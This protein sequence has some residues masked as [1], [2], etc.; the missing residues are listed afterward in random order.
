[1]AVIEQA[2]TV[3]GQLAWVGI[4]AGVLA[5]LAAAVYRWLVGEVIPRSLAMLIG[6][7]AVALYLNATQALGQLIGGTGDATDAATALLNVGS[8]V[9]GWLAA[10]VGHRAGDAFQRSVFDR[11]GPGVTATTLNPLARSLGRAVDVTLPAEID[12]LVGYDP[13]APETKAALAGQSFVFPRGLTVE[14]LRERL[15]T[16]LRT[17]FDVGRVDV[18]LAPDGTVEYLAVGS[19]QA[20]IGPTLAPGTRAIA[21][22][23]DPAFSA[24]AGDLVQVWRTDPPER[25][26]TAEVRGIAGDVVTLAVDAADADALDDLTEYRLVTL[27]VESRPDREF[28]ALLRAAD[29]TFS[30]VTVEAGSGLDGLTIGGLA[31][32]VVAVSPAGERLSVLPSRTTVLSSGDVAYA[33][34]RPDAL[35][36][37]EA[38]ARGPAPGGDAAVTE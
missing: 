36:R 32:D 5:A 24:G 29:E 4:I 23:A 28:A 11:R 14:E 16:R 12:D 7:G 27:P 33:I 1:M 3:A 17:D 18:D 26:L 22:R 30:S 38:A 37:L 8:F 21:I 25:V 15:V 34:A 10:A 31:V 6:L 19:R 2:A 13:V 20:G 9:V 35:R